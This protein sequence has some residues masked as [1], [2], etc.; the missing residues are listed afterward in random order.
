MNYTVASTRDIHNGQILDFIKD[1]N[2]YNVGLSNGEKFITKKFRTIG[3]ATK[4]YLE[5]ASYFIN[6]LYSFEQRAKLLT[7]KEL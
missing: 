5:I 6:G 3:E 4:I 1:G 2:T 7:N